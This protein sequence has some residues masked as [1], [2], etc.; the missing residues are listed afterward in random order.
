MLLKAVRDTSLALFIA[1]VITWRFFVAIIGLMVF[2]P[3][4][5]LEYF[6]ERKK[7]ISVKR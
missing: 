1:L 3:L 5:F 2:L 6:I 4:W 7:P